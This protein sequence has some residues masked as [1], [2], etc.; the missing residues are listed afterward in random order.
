MEEKT[1]T[2]IKKTIEELLEKMG[3]TAQVSISNSEELRQ[4]LNNLMYD[5]NEL[6]KASKICRDY[7]EKNVGST[8]VIINKVFNI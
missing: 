7:V 5:E 6:G 8:K 4:V 2:V 3:F 1:T